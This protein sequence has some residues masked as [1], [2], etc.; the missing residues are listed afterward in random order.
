MSPRS[1]APHSQ[2]GRHVVC[3][4]YL[5][6]SLAYQ[7]YG[8]GLDPRTASPSLQ[9]TGRP[10]GLM[11]DLTVLLDVPAEVAGGA[12]DV[13]TARP[14][15]GR[16]ARVPP[17]RCS[18]AT[19]RSP[20]DPGW[21]VVDGSRPAW[22]TSQLRCGPRSATVWLCERTAVDVDLFR[23]VIG[24][25]RAV[26][27]LRA[28]AAADPVHAYLFVGP[29]GSGKR[30]AAHAFAAALLAPPG[31]DRDDRDAAACTRG[32]ASRLC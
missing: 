15:R 27:Q 7:G 6:S 19:G 21:V 10:D 25:D 31:A 29:S 20:T 32:H 9:S 3:D 11:P 8:R 2:D 18:M 24:Q 22:T 17:A 30:A 28:A 13:G 26:A 14:V 1:S 23:E 4:R 5:G 12:A 16:R